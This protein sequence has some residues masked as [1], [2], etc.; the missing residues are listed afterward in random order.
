MA[1]FMLGSLLRTFKQVRPLLLSTPLPLT[2]ESHNPRVPHGSATCSARWFLHQ[3]QA[4]FEV[5]M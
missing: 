5:T 4:K 3:L 1:A 2:A